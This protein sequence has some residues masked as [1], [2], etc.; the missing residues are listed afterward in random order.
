M[1][2]CCLDSIFFHRLPEEDAGKMKSR[3]SGMIRAM[4]RD[5]AWRED[6]FS[7]F[8]FNQVWYGLIG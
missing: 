7:G 1:K 8:F 4:G 3:R 5:G 6:V 2:R